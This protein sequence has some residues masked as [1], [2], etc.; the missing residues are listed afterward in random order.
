MLQGFPRSY[1]F[2]KGKREA[3]DAGGPGRLIGNAVP[4][5]FGRAVGKTFLEVVQISESVE[6]Q[7]DVA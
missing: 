7:R 3:L 2:V 6:I 4:P 1:R 5:A